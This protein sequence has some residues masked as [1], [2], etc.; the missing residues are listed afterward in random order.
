M[1]LFYFSTISLVCD[2]SPNREIRYFEDIYFKIELCY[3]ARTN[4][5][6]GNGGIIYLK[7]IICEME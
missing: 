2:F 6:N 4:T 1:N 3:F 5:Y 7:D